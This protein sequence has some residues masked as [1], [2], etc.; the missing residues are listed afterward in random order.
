MMTTRMMMMGLTMMGLVM[1]RRMKMR[2]GA[3][4]QMNLSL[5]MIIMIILMPVIRSTM[6]MVA[7]VMKIGMMALEKDLDRQSPT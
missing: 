3:S 5:A 1:T 6:T 4:A 7:N 2:T